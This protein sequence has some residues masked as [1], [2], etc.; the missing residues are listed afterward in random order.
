MD[1]M[2]KGSEP[3]S[4]SGVSPGTIEHYLREGLR[5]SGDEIGRT[6]RNMA[7]L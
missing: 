3:A 4:R 7:H 1:G 6:S 5:G 2:L